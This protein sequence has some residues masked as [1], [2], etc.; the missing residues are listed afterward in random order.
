M[1]PPRPAPRGPRSGVPDATPDSPTTA[2]EVALF[3]NDADLAR[4]LR[5]AL[6]ALAVVTATNSATLTQ[7]LKA[8]RCGTVVLDVSALGP[9]AV[10]AVMRL[11]NRYPRLPLIAVGSRL[12]E[13]RLA[14]LISAGRIYRFLHRPL[15][16]ARARRFLEAALRRHAAVAAPDEHPVPW[17]ELRPTTRAE[18][19][20]GLLIGMGTL[21][22]IAGIVLWTVRP[23]SRR[24]PASAARPAMTTAAVS[25]AVPLAVVTR[26]PAAAAPEPV[27]PPHDAVM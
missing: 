5:V 17:F 7:I 8:G 12:D 25:T 3:S 24:A 21:L 18:R 23:A 14:H 15:S 2:A 4:Q 10:V 13:T 26:V 20:G 16:A 27:R 9:A 22:I 6:P 19:R 1:T 11:Y